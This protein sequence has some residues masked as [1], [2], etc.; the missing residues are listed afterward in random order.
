MDF[1]MKRYQN[2]QEMEKV[3]KRKAAS[4]MLSPIVRAL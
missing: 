1:E 2:M 4:S 3:S